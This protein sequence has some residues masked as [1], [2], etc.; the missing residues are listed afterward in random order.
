MV[1]VGAA[2]LAVLEREGC[3]GR[4]GNRDRWR[5]PC[6][7]RSPWWPW[8]SQA[9]RMQCTKSALAGSVDNVSVLSLRHCWK[10]FL[11]DFRF[12][13]DSCRSHLAVKDTGG[14]DGGGWEAAGGDGCR[15]ERARG[16][17]RWLGVAVSS[18]KALSW[19][20]A[21]GADRIGP[22]RVPAPARSKLQMGSAV[23]GGRGLGIH[24]AFTKP[25]GGTCQAKNIPPLT[26]PSEVVG[27]GCKDTSPTRHCQGEA[28]LACSQTHVAQCTGTRAWPDRIVAV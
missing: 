27:T 9:A 12:S 3:S 20:R 14:R 4:V 6:G 18:C 24:T 25:I 22:A 21:V 5:G 10:S 11:I 26:H 17:P 13:S 8:I 2:E 16:G 23:F 7:G 15:R 19:C 28:L 1:H